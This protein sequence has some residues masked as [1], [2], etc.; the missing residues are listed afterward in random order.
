[1]IV[2]AIKQPRSLDVSEVWLELK[3]RSLRVLKPKGSQLLDGTVVRVR[4]DRKASSIVLPVVLGVREDGPE[5]AI[6]ME[7]VLSAPDHPSAA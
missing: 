3:W 6:V 7:S 2:R 5:G 1:V 4:L